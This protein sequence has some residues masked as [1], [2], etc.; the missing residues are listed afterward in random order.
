MDEFCSKKDTPHLDK[1]EFF[2]SFFSLYKIEENEL[3]KPEE[4]ID[5][6]YQKI[7]SDILMNL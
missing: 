3:D 2:N 6:T 1:K 5:D 4:N 7:K